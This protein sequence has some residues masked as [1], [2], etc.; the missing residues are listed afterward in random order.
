MREWTL[1]L[2]KHLAI[3]NSAGLAGVV[4]LISLHSGPTHLYKRY[5]I[6]A[7]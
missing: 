6:S 4:A 2:V 7:C 3:V 1:E 5:L